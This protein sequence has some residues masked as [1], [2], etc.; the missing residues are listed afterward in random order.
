MY[1][2]W[3]ITLYLA[4][5]ELDRQI[6]WKVSDRWLP[7]IAG[8]Y[9]W[10]APPAASLALPGAG[11]L[12]NRQPVK[13]AAG[14]LGAIAIAAVPR[15]PQLVAVGLAW[16]MLPWYIIVVADALVFGVLYRGNVDDFLD[17]DEDDPM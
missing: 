14:L 8:P 1:V 10:Y 17:W 3:C 9:P 11:Q 13:A 15:P 2:L 12:L 4:A 7:G 5:A 6:G 16:L